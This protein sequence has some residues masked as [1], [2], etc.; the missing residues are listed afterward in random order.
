VLKKFLSV[1]SAAVKLREPI[2]VWGEPGLG[3]TA[4]IEDMARRMGYH[5]EIVI[6]SHHEPT[7]FNGLPVVRDGEGVDRE[8]PDWA[9]R[10][11]NIGSGILFLDEISTA[12]PAT[13]AALLR[14]VLERT[15]GNMKLPNDVT[16]VMA[17][18]PPE[19]AAGGWDLTPPMA[20]RLTHITFPNDVESWVENFPVYWGNPP[21]V[22]DLPEAEWRKSRILVASFINHRRDILQKIPNDE[23]LMGRPWPSRRSWDKVSRYMT[24]LDGDSLLSAVMGCVGEGP[25]LEFLHWCRELDLPDPHELLRNPGQFTVPERGDQAYAVLSSV[26]MAATEDITE[27]KWL[28][29]WRILARA[30]EQGK[31]DVASFAAMRLVG[32]RKPEFEIPHSDVEMFGKFLDSAGL[33]EREK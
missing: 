20:N 26:V 27:E 18:N 19:Q 11:S 5:L 15:V 1:L 10:L 30:G 23:T 4:T 12:P 14:V 8:P 32:E 25:A 33:M 22:N 29:C 17:A 2:V 28:A 16:I 7:D 3:K 6:A 9:R 13:Q 21:K 31:K 24:E